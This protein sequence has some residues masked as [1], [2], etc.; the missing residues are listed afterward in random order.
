MSLASNLIAFAQAVGAD[1]K[2]VWTL[3]NG[4]ATNLSA[5][6][7][8]TKTNLV[9]AINEIN[10]KP[11]GGGAAINDTTASAT[12]TFSGEKINNELAGKSPTSHSHAWS[13]IT[14]KPTTFAPTAHS[15][16]TA[17]VTGLDTALGN[18]L[19]VDASQTLTAAQILQANNNLDVGDTTTNFAAAYATARDA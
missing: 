19:R 3:V 7:T 2:T 10:A 5:L 8:T 17:E 9:A 4:R 1:V 6:T 13:A 12:T 11:S 14:G 15:H 18:R 16:G